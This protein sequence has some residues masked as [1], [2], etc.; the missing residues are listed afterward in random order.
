MSEYIIAIKE[1]NPCACPCRYCNTILD[2]N[3]EIADESTP[4]GDSIAGVLIG[5]RE[6]LVF[7][8][9]I[10]RHHLNNG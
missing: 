8:S 1:L 3:A 6:E 4:Y 10:H 9:F 7:S 5:K 2:S